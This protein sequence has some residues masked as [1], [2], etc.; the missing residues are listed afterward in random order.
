MARG[1]EGFGA[2][3]ILTERPSILSG[4]QIRTVKSWRRTLERD[5]TCLR[6]R[7]R[8]VVELRIEVLGMDEQRVV[9]AATIS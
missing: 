1:Y 8:V 9:E 7:G 5:T 2:G 4:R 6:D 3:L